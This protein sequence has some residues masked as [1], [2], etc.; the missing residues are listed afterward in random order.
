MSIDMKY[1]MSKVCSVTTYGHIA[2]KK[3]DYPKGFRCGVGWD[4]NFQN[5]DLDVELWTLHL[6][7]CA[8]LPNGNVFGRATTGSHRRCQNC[9]WASSRRGGKP[10]GASPGG[11]GLRQR[12]LGFHVWREPANERGLW[13]GESPAR[14]ATHEE[15]A[16][17]PGREGEGEEPLP[18]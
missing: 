8:V 12:F 17:E 3:I 11:I 4:F 13:E 9:D 2:S 7:G 10:D 14:S 16:P 15:A 1:E 18:Y 5:V 6:R